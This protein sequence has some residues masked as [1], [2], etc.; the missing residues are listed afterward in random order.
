MT[1]ILKWRKYWRNQTIHKPGPSSTEYT[2]LTLLESGTTCEVKPPSMLTK[3]HLLDSLCL[4]KDGH[5]IFSLC[6]AL[7]LPFF[8]L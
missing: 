3:R 2:N 5:A 8:N 6:N 1:K 7:S 4:N